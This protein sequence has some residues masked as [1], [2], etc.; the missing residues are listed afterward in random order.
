MATGN[1]MFGRL[2]KFYDRLYGVG[3]AVKLIHGQAALLEDELRRIALI[4][5]SNDSDAN[6]VH[7]AASGEEMLNWFSSSKRALLAPFGAGTV[8]QVELAGLHTRYYMLKLFSLAGKIVVVDEVHAYDAY[9][10]MILE[11]TLQWLAALGT[12]V[13]LLSA[14]LPAQRHAALA[15]ACMQGVSGDDEHTIDTPTD[16]HYPVLSIYNAHGQRRLEVD[17]FRPEQRLALQFIHDEGYDTQ[18]Q[19]LLDLVAEGGAVARL[20][21]RVDDAQG[22]FAAL[23]RLDPPNCVLIHARFPL[24][25]R[26]QLEYRVNEL[27]GRDTQR[28]TTDRVIIVGTQ[29]LEQS[30]DYDVDVMVTDLAPIDLLLQRAGRLHRHQRDRLPRFRDAV[31]YVQFPL[32][33]D[34]LP[35]WKRWKRIYDAYILW[36]TWE[37][38]Q[39][40]AANGI[41][42]IMLPNDYRPLIEAVYTSE[43]PPLDTNAPYAEAM[44]QAWD[45]MQKAQR[46]MDGEAK[47]RLTPNPLRRDGITRG[48][49]L[50]FIEDEDGALTGWLAAKTRLGDRVTAIPL[51]RVD[52]KLSLDPQGKQLLPKKSPTTE[53]QTALLNRALPVSDPRL[54]DVL[55]RPAQ[56]PWGSKTPALLEHVYPLELDTNGATKLAGI[57]I[58]LDS[59]LGLTLNGENHD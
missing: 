49:E 51:Y 24:E 41:T 43:L 42:L 59:L 45:A 31:M 5:P 56:W 2:S 4:E 46:T 50:Q 47:L 26:K 16:L 25:D 37:V 1:Q 8:D 12:S 28:T 13:I 11:H 14:T 39:N 15:T 58:Q 48:D 21:N 9:M 44:Q 6:T 32:A 34:D 10:N 30:L 3:G 57:T 40:R 19:R 23:Q 27:V 52:G 35:D 7:W 53:Q 20:C 55:R 33:A 17:A 22:I 18:A 54:I 29:V 38:L 36:R